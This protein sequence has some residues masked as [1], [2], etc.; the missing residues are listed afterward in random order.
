MERKHTVQVGDI[1][2][3]SFTGECGS[4]T[5]FYQVV[6]L[7]G[8]TLV[9]ICQI[10]CDFLID[11]TCDPARSQ[12]RAYPQKDDF[13]DESDVVATRAYFSTCG[14]EYCLQTIVSKDNPNFRKYHYPYRA[15]H[16]YRFSG[17]NGQFI[18]DRLGLKPKTEE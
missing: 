1:F 9:D 4:S 7:R 3:F 13:Y 10:G 18:I 17:Y 12:C 14:N 15:E 5:S 2:T 16:I 6:R 8:K 11:E